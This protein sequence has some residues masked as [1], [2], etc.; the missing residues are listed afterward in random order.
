MVTYSDGREGNGEG[1][2][3]NKNSGAQQGPRSHA[4]GSFSAETLGGT[5]LYKERSGWTL[6]IEGL[7]QELW[8]GHWRLC[9]RKV[10][11]HR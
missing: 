5:S 1:S 9:H 4:S 10:E 6:L 2:G 8:V 7:E 11:H 3:V